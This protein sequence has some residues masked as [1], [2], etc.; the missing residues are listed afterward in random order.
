MVTQKRDGMEPMGTTPDTL[1]SP[2]TLS[3]T[4]H[5]TKSS[6][7]LSYVGHSVGERSFH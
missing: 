4:L 1:H 5:C 7:G 2:A 6:Q 3:T